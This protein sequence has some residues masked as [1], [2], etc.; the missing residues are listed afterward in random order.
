MD[1]YQYDESLKEGGSTR[2]A[3]IDEA[4]RGPIAGPVVAVA[5]VLKEGA[6]VPRLRDS[7]KV[8]EKE[9]E[10]LFNSL[11][12]HVEDLGIG[13]A[14]VQVIERLNI[15]GAT[16][17]AMQEAVR[18]LMEVPG[19][20]LIDALELPSLRIKQIPIIKGD[21]KSASIAAASVVAKLVRDRI[22]FRYHKLYPQYGFDRHKGYCTAEHVMLV[23]KYGPS[24]IHR[25]GFKKVSTIRLPF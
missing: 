18:N 13:I 22:M 4:G 2:A 20:L 15:L 14:G 17:Y 24:P 21:S 3:G 9:R 11:I 25:M 19:L 1:I 12:P 16:K 7:K 5:V 8:P 10:P 23:E 6:R